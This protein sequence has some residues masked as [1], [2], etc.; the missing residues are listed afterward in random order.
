MSNAT[1]GWAFLAYNSF[2]FLI[3]AASGKSFLH[4]LV[5]PD[6]QNLKHCSPHMVHWIWP[7]LSSLL[8]LPDKIPLDSTGN[9]TTSFLTIRVTTQLFFFSPWNLVCP[10]MTLWFSAPWLSPYLS[11]LVQYSLPHRSPLLLLHSARCQKQERLSLQCVPPPFLHRVPPFHLSYI[12]PKITEGSSSQTLGDV[13]MGWEEMN[14]K[15]RKG[16]KIFS[17]CLL[18]LLIRVYTTVEKLSAKLSNPPFFLPPFNFFVNKMYLLTRVWNGYP[19]SPT[20]RWTRG[21]TLTFLELL[22]IISSS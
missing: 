20:L 16:G 19:V 2:C 14:C 12:S 8:A 15:E 6:I 22:L 18:C 21:I 13:K 1:S 9:P 7:G 5:K 17:L 10:C 4:Q 3:T 11:W